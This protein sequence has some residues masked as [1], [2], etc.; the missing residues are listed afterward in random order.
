MV[1]DGGTG[2]QCSTQ[3]TAAHTDSGEPEG[4]GLRHAELLRCGRKVSQGPFVELRWIPTV[5]L[6]QC[7]RGVYCKATRTPGAILEF[8]ASLYLHA[9]LL[10]L[11]IEWTTPTHELHR[12]CSNTL[13][14]TSA[15]HP[16]QASNIHR[17]NS[18]RK[19]ELDRDNPRGKMETYPAKTLPGPS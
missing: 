11:H 12:P 14:D 17:T 9:A 7:D 8:A 18:R 19:Q 4:C 6:P 5:K 13:R 1:R 3:H 15:C 2:R 10:L 16:P